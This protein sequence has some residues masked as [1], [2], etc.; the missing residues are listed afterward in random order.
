M[1]WITLRDASLNGIDTSLPQHDS[2]AMLSTDGFV[3]ANR[4]LEVYGKFALSDRTY[5]Y[6]GAAPLSTLTYLWQ[7]RVQN[8][9]HGRRNL[10]HIHHSQIAVAR[11][12]SADGEKRRAHLWVLGRKAMRAA[13]ARNWRHSSGGVSGSGR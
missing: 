13:A 8:P 9:G 12:A 2:V 10:P 11:D 4:W 7:G 3:Q 5:N 6:T 1:D